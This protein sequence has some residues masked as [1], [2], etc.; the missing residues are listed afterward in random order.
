M[1][2]PVSILHRGVTFTVDPATELLGV[3][4]IL[5]ENQDAVCDAGRERCN[6]Q[7][8]DEVL[9]FFAPF[10]GC[11]VTKQLETF[12][13][14]YNFNYDAPVALFLHLFHGMP[15]NREELFRFRKPIPDE[16]FDAFIQSAY[17]FRRESC[18]D[19]FYDSHQAMYEQLLH[20]FIADYDQYDPL[21][22]LQN[23]LK[24][25]PD[26]DYCINLMTG[27][28]N[29]NYGVALGNTLCTNICPNHRTRYAPLP[30]FS[31]QPIYWTTL[32]VH[33]FAHPFVNPIVYQHTA[34]V[35]T[36]DKA[37]Y[38]TLLQELMYGDSMETYI[39]ETLIRAI[40]CLY[41]Q[42]VFPDKH[43]DYLQEYMDEAYI[44][45]RAAEQMLLA[46]DGEPLLHYF[47]RFLSLF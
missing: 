12:S 25:P 18:F 1:P 19:A 46:H 27:V 23:Y 13:D 44:H 9:S 28:T 26:H 36:I 5:C 17:R 11:T 24:T 40:E 3:L 35:S 45:I 34:A 32:I 41:V 47:S 37:P 33:E 15:V 10:R 2:S 31:F 43:E 7:Y 30:D 22:F 39:A 6:K 8:R 20:H 21:G 38:H 14:R 42:K 4:S 29:S 16:A